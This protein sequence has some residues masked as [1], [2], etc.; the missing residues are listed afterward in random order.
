M[1]SSSEDCSSGDELPTPIPDV[2]AKTNTTTKA[3]PLTIPP[4]SVSCVLE[5]TEV[6]TP[7]GYIRIET[8]KVGDTVVSDFG[9][10]CR[11]AK[12][13]RWVETYET[14]PRNE[15]KIVYKL[16]KG[17]YRAQS[18]VFLTHYH[19]FLDPVQWKLRLPYIAGLEVATPEEIV[20]PPAHTYVLYHIRL[21]NIEDNL[22]VNGGCVI[23][24]WKHD[25]HT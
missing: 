19:R 8:L 3:P 18:D 22:V 1:A 9:K 16:P 13:G 17:K 10:I 4:P 6:Y 25:D 7:R 5:G 23:E 20:Q 12:I 11:I 21:E 2:P 24:S 14:H 15:S